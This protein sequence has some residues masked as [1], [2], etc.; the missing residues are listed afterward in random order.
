MTDQAAARGI[1]EQRRLEARRAA[2]QERVASSRALL[3]RHAAIVAASEA[4]I[5]SSLTHLSEMD[6]RLRALHRGRDALPVQVRR[7]AG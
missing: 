2:L 6:E 1:P 5:G 3:Q 4:A 7:R